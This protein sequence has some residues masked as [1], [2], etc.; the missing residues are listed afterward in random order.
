VI[1]RVY[2]GR[3]VVRSN[4]RGFTATPPAI[5]AREQFR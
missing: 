1:K 5:F 4:N 3:I 2:P